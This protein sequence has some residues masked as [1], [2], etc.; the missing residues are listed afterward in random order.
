MQI[1]FTIPDDKVARITD[2]MA[3]LY[4]IPTDDG[5]VPLFTEGQWAKEKLRR[6]IISLVYRY[7]IREAQIDAAAAVESDDGLV[8]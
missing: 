7:E 5:G 8:S 3:G 6:M 1:I 2:A 4:P